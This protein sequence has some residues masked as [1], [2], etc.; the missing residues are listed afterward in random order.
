[1][2]HLVGSSLNEEQ[3]ALLI[4]RAM[5]ELAERRKRDKRFRDGVGNAG[6]GGITFGEFQVILEGAKKLP[7]VVV[8][9]GFD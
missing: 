6:S 5:G 9:V 3:V 8:P 4:T 7:N 1:M 2:K